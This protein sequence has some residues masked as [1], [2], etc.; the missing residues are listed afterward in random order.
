MRTNYSD[1]FD[2]VTVN[3]TK[4]NYTSHDVYRFF[5]KVVG[6][7]IAQKLLDLELP[8]KWATPEFMQ[9]IEDA[10]D[11]S[12]LLQARLPIQEA[13]NA[14]FFRELADKFKSS[15]EDQV[16][17]FGYATHD[18]TLGP[19]MEAVGA[20]NKTRPLYGEALIFTLTA[21]DQLSVQF[22]DIN[23]RLTQHTMP[24]CNEDSCTFAQF[25]DS[26]N[27][28]PQDWQEACKATE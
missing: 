5:D 18:T 1:L 12:F 28:M 7:I 20:W 8:Q 26:V 16:S 11:Y 17:F 14:V 15:A 24:G 25:E 23:R 3:I 10:L 22:L 19:L 13:L 6:H 4:E 21:D 9:D 2:Y 27:K